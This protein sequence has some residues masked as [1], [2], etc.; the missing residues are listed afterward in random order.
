MTLTAII[1]GTGLTRLPGFAIGSREKIPTEWGDPSADLIHGKL[2]G[3][4]I[5]F[6]ARHGERHTIP[7]HRI[8]YRANIKALKDLGVDAIIAAAAVGGIR[9]DMGPAKLVVPSQLIDY[10]HG[11]ATTFFEDRLDH[12]TH[13]D[14]THPYTETLRQQLLDAGF[15]AGLRI[16]DG[17]VYACTQGPRLETPA[18]IVRIERDGG[19]MVGMT[20]MPEAALA[21]ELEIDYACCAIVAN[22]AAGKSNQEIT[23]ADI[24]QNLVQGMADFAALLERLFA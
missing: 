13:I 23:M 9:A 21:R 15:R 5:V 4:D 22:W 17:G 6:L 14:F 7:P 8:N 19:D 16:V 12:V 3:V 20:G 18:E 11:R 24:E 10:S 1:G 2:H